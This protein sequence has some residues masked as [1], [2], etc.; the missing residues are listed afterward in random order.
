MAP[1]AAAAGQQ[2]AHRCIGMQHHHAPAGRGV[3]EQCRRLARIERGEQRRVQ[4]QRVD[5]R[6]GR[7]QSRQVGGPQRDGVEARQRQRATPGQHHA[8]QRRGR[9]P[10]LHR[11]RHLTAVGSARARGDRLRRRH[12]HPNPC[13][14]PRLQRQFGRDRLPPRHDFQHD[15]G[16]LAG[17]QA[18]VDLGRAIGA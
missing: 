8:Q 7:R 4:H 14:L 16:R 15:A 10:D 18:D 9:A 11:L 2:L 13:R 17:R 6:V 5:R 12:R 3:A 1:A